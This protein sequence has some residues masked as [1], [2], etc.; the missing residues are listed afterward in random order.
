MIIAANI[1]IKNPLRYEPERIFIV[2]IPFLAITLCLLLF[3]SSFFSSRGFFGRSLFGRCFGSG[4]CSSFSSFLFS[5]CFCFHFVDLLFCFQTCF[6]FSFL[7]FGVFA[8]A[9]SAFSAAFSAFEAAF[10]IFGL[11]SSSSVN[12]SLVAFLAIHHPSFTS[13][14]SESFVVMIR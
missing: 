7:F 6:S 2:L 8:A 9:R 14:T 13:A 10:L 4:F 1:V 5:Q 12:R 3:G 11:A